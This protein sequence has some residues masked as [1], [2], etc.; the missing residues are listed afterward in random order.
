MPVV[1]NVLSKLP[2]LHGPWQHF[3]FA[4]IGAFS[5]KAHYDWEARLIERS[6]VSIATLKSGVDLQT[7]RTDQFREEYQKLR[8]GQIDAAK[9]KAAT[10]PP[11]VSHH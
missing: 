8:Q 9:E 4:I 2:L 1:M 7:A 6:Q 3:S 11:P 10:Q 5:V